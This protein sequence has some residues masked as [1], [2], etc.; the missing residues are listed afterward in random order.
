MAEETKTDAAGLLPPWKLGDLP[1][2]P[3]F[4]FRN[5][6]AVI[7]PGT[8]AL[9]MSIGGG[10]WLLGPATI[11]KYG[12]SVM[13]IVMLGILF[14][15]VLNYEFLRYTLYTGE[16]TMQGFMRTKPGP[17]FWAVFYIVLALCQVGWPAWA[18]S[19]SSAIFASFAGRLPDTKLPD[20]ASIMRYIGIGTF[21]LTVV[22][23]AFG[24]KIERTLEVVNMFMVV[25]IVLFLVT[26]NVLFIPWRI[27]WEGFIGHFGLK[28]GAGG[29]TSF[30]FVP[31]GVDWVLLGGFAG[32]AGNGGI[33]NIWTANWIRDK[34][35]GMG[36]TVGY[37]P[38]AVGGKVVKV[39][40]IGTVFPVNEENL[41]RWRNWWKYVKVDQAWVWAVGCFL[42]MYL[43]VILAAGLIQEGTDIGKGLAPGATQAQYIAD[44]AATHF[45]S[46]TAGKIF[47]FM[48]LLN[49]FWILFGTQ[50]CIVDG[51]VR[52][53]TDIAWSG[54]GRIREAAKGDIRKVY[55]SLLGIFAVWGCIA[56]N[57]SQPFALMKIA[58]NA[59]G[60]ILTIAGIHVIVLNRKV[61]PRE[62]RARPWQQAM[63]YLAVCYSAFFVV[64]NVYGVWRELSQPK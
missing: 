45:S 58:A 36:S 31:P 15:L 4:N 17:G 16:P 7:G 23:V 9:S 3:P 41:S 54:S 37:I 29:S 47:W 26:V 1:A 12:F 28:V 19:S 46:E 2:P 48:T 25:F 57:L 55:Y 27:W 10:E 34:G 51:F 11:V 50:M 22:I 21:L 64:M 59:A 13:W 63:V 5:I 61:I 24:G 53:T 49:G 44:K 40:P 38:S 20:H 33:G 8:I 18:A 39:S 56:I 60:V 52:L 32:F 6:L 62:L 30:L 14:Q 42:G 43:N 35:M